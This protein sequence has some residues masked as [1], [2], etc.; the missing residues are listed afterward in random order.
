LPLLAH[1]APQTRIVGITIGQTD[2]AQCGQIASAV[3]DVLRDRL[4]SVHLLISSD[5]NHF[6]SDVE[7]RRLDE[8]ALQA[9]DRLDPD[10]LFAT[11]HQQ[12][13]SMCGMLPAVIVLKTL[14]NLHALHRAVRVD[15]ATSAEV[16]G[17]DRQ[18]VG[19]AGMLFD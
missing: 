11:C 8:L 1:L 19:Y 4:D 2:L 16:S 14:Q 12:R 18:V 15:Y 13:I 7:N 5:M 6:A 17:D 10:L 9:L 3:A